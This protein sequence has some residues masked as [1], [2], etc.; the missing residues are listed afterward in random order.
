MIVDIPQLRS[1]AI[2]AIETVQR[3]PESAKMPSVKTCWPE[4]TRDSAG[5]TFPVRLLPSADQISRADRFFEAL[6]R[7]ESEVERKE[8][9]AWGRVQTSRNA[10]IRGYADKMGLREHE[11]RRSIDKIFQKV[12]VHFNRNPGSLL[13]APVEHREEM[14]H[15]QPTSH[16]ARATH[17]MAEDAKPRASDETPQRQNCMR[18]MLARTAERMGEAQGRQRAEG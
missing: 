17:W 1:I 18:A 9:Y 15:K 8:I 13:F 12:A 3:L 4:W 10:T 7:L 5:E 6:N 16:E 2:E 11:Y 14:G